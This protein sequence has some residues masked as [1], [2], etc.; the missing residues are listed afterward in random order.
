MAEDPAQKTG[1][2]AIDPMTAM[3]WRC[4]GP[5]R[6]GR[7][8]AVAGDPEDLAVFYFGA[9]AGGVWKTTDA[10]AYWENVS[11]GFFRTSAVGAI[12][13]AEADHNVV[14][15]G[16][17]ESCIRGDVSYGDGVYKS[18]DGGKTWLHMGLEDTRHIA[19]IR[20]H[21][22]NADLVYV[23]ALGHAF[24]PNSERGVFRSNDGCKSWEKVLFRDENTGAIDL[25]LDPTNPR[26]LYAALWEA[27]RTPWSLIS[28][29]PG[30]GVFK[31]TDGG[32][33]WQELTGNPGLPEGLKGRIGI[34]ASPAKPGRVWATV[35]AEDAALFRSDDGGATW[36]KVSD[37]QDIQ[38]RPWYYQHIFADPQDA[39][40]VW[41]LNYQ[42]WK[43]IDGGKNFQQV[44]TP[45]GD[46]HDLWIDP[47]NTQRMIEGNDGGACVSFNGG[48]TWSTIY[49][50]LT[51]QF[52]HI[53]TD[54]Q[55]PY[56]VY[57]TQQDNS[58]ISVPS[59]THKGAI[60][61]GDC[62]TVGNSESGHITVHPQ[63]P[64]IVVS[65]A[66]GSSAGGG[67]NLLRY[68]HATGQVRIITVWPELLTGRGA[69]EMKYRF[70]WTFPVQFSLHDPDVLYVAGN[71]VFRSADQGS[72]WE[73]ISP[74]L[75]RGDVT[76]ME[77]SGG[78][79]TK[80]T[81]GA[82]TYGTIFAFAESPHQAGVFWAGSDDGLV[83]I[84]QDAGKTWSDITPADLQEWSL[85][86]MIEASPHDPAK[87]Y[88]AATSYKLDETRPMIYKTSDNGG[89]WTDISQGIPEGDYTR[90]IREDPVRRGL[91]YVGTETGVYV[92]FDDG[93]SW[94]PLQG[95]LPNVPV[96]DLAV[97]END[98]VAATHGRSFWVLDDLSV[99]HQIN[100]E[101]AE[102]PVQLLKSRPSVRLRSPGAP[103]KPSTGK[104][105][106]LSLGADVTYTEET[107]PAGETVRRFL[108]AG[109]NPPRGVN[110]TYY[111]K[112]KPEGEVILTVFDSEKQ[113]I[114]SF[115]SAAPK[116]SSVAGAGDGGREPRLPAEAGVNRFVWDMRYP[117]ARK[118]P[119]DK[120]TEDMNTGP[121]AP[122]GNY[123]LSLRVDGKELTGEFQIVKD[124]R[125]AASQADFD[126]QF[127]LHLGIR[128]KL[129]ET[130]DSIN[131]LRNIRRQVEEWEQRAASHSAAETV[132][133][134][135]APLK[136]KLA[137]IEGE[138]VQTGYKGARD[139]LNLPVKLNRKLAELVIVV[140]SADFAPPKQAGEVFQD[141]SAR[142]DDQIS[143]LEDVVDRD[144]AQFVTLVE[145][146]GI[147]A[148]IPSTVP[149]GALTP[150]G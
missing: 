12:T 100:N 77:T 28:G 143:L 31:S 150:S 119:G 90:V 97:K 104:Q 116:D 84:S 108:D 117:D 52:Y 29:G 74:D 11:D 65:G 122:P 135:A 148:I 18:T 45:H 136:E 141:L 128:D 110:V 5:P 101:L 25:S 69:K 106:R 114:K 55:Y 23:A 40:T 68:D 99:L 96:Y 76:K 80:D 39:E 1:I 37:N 35:E 145:E 62:Y 85:V 126:S 102:S 82:E 6:G 34:A 9:C 66:V 78:P 124:P 24:G 47:N 137:D 13:V 46:N 130:H 33:S 120:T 115:T 50:Q 93:G 8:V 10:G 21:P 118:V 89:S 72:S 127:A 56:R 30:S 112:E 27:Q 57:G 7:V 71:L 147:P 134:A 79:V 32:D 60:P 26:V 121:A 139:R 107:G 41:V 140:G 146:L 83:H 129:S 17:G 105:Y 53:A 58:A 20:V 61:W 14:Y 111:L 44:T 123:H 98:L 132:A 131:K 3:R 15:A 138:L 87:A 142:I 92:S 51:A 64:N 36:E 91:L 75:T 4:I 144:I 49:N 113:L 42:A 133:A 54:N 59:R 19:R 2:A 16:M 63:D 86:S 22:D 94:A 48:D 43:S 125:V 70:Q 95:N 149:P 73:A 67:G 88:L 103:R 109:E 81:S 38:G